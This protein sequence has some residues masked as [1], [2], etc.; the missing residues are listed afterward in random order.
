[1]LDQLHAQNLI[2]SLLVLGWV[3]TG[4]LWVFGLLM[5][6][7]LLAWMLLWTLLYA[8]LPTWGHAFFIIIAA[9]LVL[10]GLASLILGEHAADTMIGN[11]AADL[12]RLVVRTFLL[13]LRII[14]R[15]LERWL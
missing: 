14:L 7:R 11:L 3:L 6:R 5:A 1:M 10:Q 9:L 13:P 15:L 12:V 2:T 4:I 8:F